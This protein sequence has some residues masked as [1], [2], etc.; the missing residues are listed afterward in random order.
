MSLCAKIGILCQPMIW[1]A[2]GTR[3]LSSE[4]EEGFELPAADCLRPCVFC[5]RYHLKG[6]SSLPSCKPAIAQWP[7]CARDISRV[8]VKLIVVHTIWQNN[9]HLSQAWAYAS[10]LSHFRSDMQS[11]SHGSLLRRY[12]GFLLIKLHF[13][14]KKP[15]LGS[16]S[17]R[18]PYQIDDRGDSHGLVQ[19]SR[20]RAGCGAR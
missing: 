15:Q 3:R 5:C 18:P 2:H 17:L 9:S 12:S 7:H 11:D 16:L 13:Q 10:A 20:C 6:S 8:I 14:A 19:S 1:G 4:P